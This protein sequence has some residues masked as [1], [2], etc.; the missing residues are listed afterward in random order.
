LKD[1]LKKLG[2]YALYLAGLGA[3]GIAGYYGGPQAALIVSDI[4][5]SLLG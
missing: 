4:L 1:K 2:S 3:V 5:T